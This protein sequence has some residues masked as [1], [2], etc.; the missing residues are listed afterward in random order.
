MGNLVLAA[1]ETGTSR[2]K[3]VWMIGVPAGVS[4]TPTTVGE[5]LS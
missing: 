1:S 2:R 5:H 3:M 4:T